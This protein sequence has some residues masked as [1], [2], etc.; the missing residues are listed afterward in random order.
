MT[1]RE[2]VVKQAFDRT[3]AAPA[4]LPGSSVPAGTALAARLG[5]EWLERAPGTSCLG[6]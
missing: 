1:Q 3:V 6:T 2:L 4:I 5:I